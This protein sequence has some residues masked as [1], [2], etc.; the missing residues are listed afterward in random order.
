VGPPG[1]PF[2]VSFTLTGLPRAVHSRSAMVTLPSLKYARKVFKR[3]RAKPVVDGDDI[4]ARSR[5]SG[6]AVDAVRA[7]ARPAA[8][9]H[10][11]CGTRPGAWHPHI[12][13]Q[14]HCPTS[15][16]HPRAQRPRARRVNA[17]ARGVCALALDIRA[18]N[19]CV[20][21]VC[22]PALGKRARTWCPCAGA[23]CSRVGARRLPAR[24]PRISATVSYT[25]NG[26]AMHM[27]YQCGYQYKYECDGH[28][29]TS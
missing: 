28:L 26:N 21:A 27:N 14:W 4:W 18:L 13:A 1:G 19:A 8:R 10:A 7:R 16:R 12:G 29:G 5:A 25:Y 2:G 15:T 24:Y 9:A 6:G 20:P 11:V 3:T 23:R 17:R 22:M